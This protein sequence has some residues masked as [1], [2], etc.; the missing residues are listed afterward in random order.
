MDEDYY[1]LK[2][3]KRRRGTE[4]RESGASLFDSPP[5]PPPHN[6]S[7]GSRTA[8]ARVEREPSKAARD[9][10]LIVRLLEWREQGMTRAELA[11]MSGLSQNSVNPRVWELLQEQPPRI[12]ER[13]VREGRAVLVHHRYVRPFGAGGAA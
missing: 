12:A 1:P 8:A 6:K 2:A 4:E 13:G 10:A 11:S 5:P 7:D 9:R 3:Q